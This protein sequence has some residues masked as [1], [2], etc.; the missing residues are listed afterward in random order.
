MNAFDKIEK[1]ASRH[2]ALIEKQLSVLEGERQA[3]TAVLSALTDGTEKKPG[4]RD[5]VLEACREVGSEAGS[6]FGTRE[7]Q[8]VLPGLAKSQIATALKDLSGAG[9]V[10]EGYRGNGP[11]SGALYRLT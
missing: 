2:L 10:F 8:E 9:I 5:R 11:S 3:W 1:L 7:I 4:V 6:R